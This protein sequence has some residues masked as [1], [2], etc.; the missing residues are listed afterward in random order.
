MQVLA[1]PR[2]ANHRQ[3]MVHLPHIQSVA[4]AG[5]TTPRHANDRHT[6]VVATHIMMQQ[7]PVIQV[8]PC[9]LVCGT[10]QDR[11]VMD[12]VVVG[13]MQW[14]LFLSSASER[15]ESG[16]G[17]QA[18]T[19]MQA[20]HASGARPCCT[21]PHHALRLKLI[22]THVH[23]VVGLNRCILFL[24]SV[25]ERHEAGHGRQACTHMQVEHG[26]AVLAAPRQPL[27]IMRRN[28]TVCSW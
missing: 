24:W 18:C 23:V 3:K 21:T 12:A 7:M 28:H 2:C 26:H 14:T 17:K 5:P 10:M 16:H 19:H 4:S 11:R 9:E 15:H 25:G 20:A 6:H 22:A 27:L 8:A 1:T 13:L